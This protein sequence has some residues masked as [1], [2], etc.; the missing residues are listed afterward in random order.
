M[1]KPRKS[2]EALPEQYP[3]SLGWGL[4]MRRQLYRPATLATA[5]VV[6]LGVLC[7]PVLRQFLP[8]LAEDASYRL[9]AKRI[10][11][12]QPPH[13]VPQNLVEQVVE[14]AGLPEELRLLDEDLAR[15]VAQAF[16]LYPWV[17]EVVSVQKAFP[18]AVRVQINYRK[19]VAMVQV[20]LGLYP[21]D[22]RGVLLPPQDFSPADARQYPLILAVVSTPQGPAGSGWGDPVVV[23]AAQLAAELAPVWKKLKL[24]AIVCPRP[25]RP[26]GSTADEGYLL[27]TSGGS[28]IVWGRGPASNDPGELS[29]EQKIGRLTEY[30]SKFG[31]LDGPEGR[32]RIDIRHWRDIR[33][34]P[35]SAEHERVDELRQ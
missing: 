7:L 30:A 5:A 26:A 13:W 24:A 3:P 16:A 31:G 11:I 28:Q 10:E 22:G 6:V 29:T 15:D 20:K 35:L 32:Y 9:P 33:R 34:E 25:G 12:T 18:A 2:T 23:D 27:T 17:E 8:D 1:P 21:V 19:P 4:A 14:R